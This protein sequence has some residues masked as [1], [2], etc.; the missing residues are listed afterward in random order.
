MGS[1][2][3]RPSSTRTSASRKITGPTRREGR[4]RIKQE[5]VRHATG[6]DQ[7]KAPG[8]GR[9][10]ALLAA[11]AGAPP[12]PARP[13]RRSSQGPAAQV[14]SM[15]TPD[16]TSATAGA[17][18]LGWP[19]MPPATD[20]PPEEPAHVLWSPHRTG[21]GLLLPARIGRGP[22]G[23]EHGTAST[24]WSCDARPQAPTTMRVITPSRRA[25]ALVRS[26]TCWPWATRTSKPHDPKP[27]RP[28]PRER[29]WQAW[30]LS[31]T[32][33]D[34]AGLRLGNVDLRACR[35][36]GVHNLDR[37]HIEGAPLLAQVPGWWLPVSAGPL[38][39]SRRHCARVPGAGVRADLLQFPE[40]VAWQA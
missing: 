29:G 13:R 1:C 24:R 14:A 39:V 4:N 40:A 17:N 26:A 12:G 36:A 16:P 31:V 15:S 32:R 8:G 9:S 27:R 6:T 30:L 34:V 11:Q 33:A 28:G 22:S 20:P 10:L 38:R 18:V 7:Q 37:L 19:D 23:H 35:F 3:Q 5:A 2:Q 25:C 21:V